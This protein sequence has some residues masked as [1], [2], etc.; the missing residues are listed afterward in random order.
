MSNSLL[1]YMP[2]YYRKSEVINSLT[3]AEKIEV[4]IFNEKLNSVLNQAFIDTADFALDRWEKELGLEVNNK[5]DKEF[6]IS[7]IKSKI[8]GE[9]TATVKLIKNVSESFSNGE[10]DVI[11]NNPK[12]EFTIKF[13]GTKGIPPNLND[14]RNI[15]EEIKPAHLGYKFEYTYLTWNEFESYNL[16]WDQWDNLNLTW[17]EFEVY[18]K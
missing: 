11:E 8:R 3:D 15:I 12:Y 13:V 4:D 10:V 16:T 2:L 18:I 5:M 14:L 6:R 1:F 7:R 9:G 17:N